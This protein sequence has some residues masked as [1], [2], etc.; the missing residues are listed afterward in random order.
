VFFISFVY[1]WKASL[2]Q[3][4]AEERKSRYCL[5]RLRL[6]SHAPVF[7]TSAII[8]LAAQP[9]TFSLKKR[10]SKLMGRPLPRGRPYEYRHRI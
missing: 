2:K 5:L 4:T 1:F 3:K 8:A 9:Q 7:A 10:Y 6:T